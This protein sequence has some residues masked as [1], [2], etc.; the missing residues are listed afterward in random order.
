M[1]RLSLII[2]IIAFFAMFE[3]QAKKKEEYPRAEIKG[4]YTYHETF[5]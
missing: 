3:V 5:V 1:N 2:T 4:G